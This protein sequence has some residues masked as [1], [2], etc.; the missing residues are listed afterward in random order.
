MTIFLLIFWI[1][2]SLEFSWCVQ[3]HV[4]RWVNVCRSAVR[5]A[6]LEIRSWWRHKVNLFF[7]CQIL[8]FSLLWIAD[9]WLSIWYSHLVKVNCYSCTSV[10]WKCHYITVLIYIAQKTQC[11]S[12]AQSPKVI[13][14][15]TFLILCKKKKK[16]F[17][18][19][20]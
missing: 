3:F 11:I 1:L 6:I 15:Y 10:Q 8:S 13:P 18:L 5:L 20:N 19:K 9:K 17:L 4:R 14:Q 12:M 2:P 16:A 7:L